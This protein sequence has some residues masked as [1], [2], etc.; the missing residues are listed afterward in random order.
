MDLSGLDDF[1]SSVDKKPAQPN[2]T[3]AP[4]RNNNPGALMPGGKLASYGSLDEGLKALDDN[5]ISYGKKGISTLE[6][7]IKRWA[8]PNENDT[9]SYIAHAA[10]VTGLDPKQ[11][12][13]LSNPLTRLQIAA[14]ITQ[15]ESGTKALY[16]ATP[17]A[18]VTASHPVAQAGGMDLSG[19]DDFVR[20]AENLK[21]EKPVQEKRATP[22][23]ST[24]AIAGMIDKTTGV[25]APVVG[26]IASDVL[27]T[28][29]ILAGRQQ[30]SPKNV[31]KDITALGTAPAG[32]ITKTTDTEAYK[33]P[34]A[35]FGKSLA[36][37][38]DTAYGVVPA[39]IGMG[40]YAAGRL[41][42]KTPEQASQTQNEI[43]QTISNPLGHLFKI[44]EDPAYK[45]NSLRQLTEFVGEHIEKG[46]DWIA[47]KTG[48]PKADVENAINAASIVTPGALAK[49]AKTKPIAAVKAGEAEARQ[50]WTRP[51]PGTEA[52]AP[53]AESGWGQSVGSAA[54]SRADLIQEGIAQAS[55]ELQAALKDIPIN[56]MNSKALERHLE[57]DSIGVQLTRGEATGDPIILSKEKNSRGEMPELA[58]HYQEK[59]QQLM[60]AIFKAKEEAMPEFSIPQIQAAEEIIDIYKNYDIERRKTI[61]AAYQALKDANGGD[62]PIDV[63]AL[64]QNIEAS[65]KDANRTH[66]VPANVEKTIEE[67][68]AKDKM[69]YD[70]FEALRTILGEAERSA[71]KAGNGN[72]KYA[73]GL[74]RDEVEN[75]PLTKETEQLKVL[76]D[77]AR[78]LA[79]SRFDDLKSDKIYK[80]IV[81][82]KVN[83]ANFFDRYITS[84][85]A[86]YAK[87]RQF[88][89]RVPETDLQ[90]YLMSGTMDW[91]IG[92]A[93]ASE[94]KGTPFANASYHRAIKQL[95]DTRKAETI[96]TPELHQKLN[97]IDNVSGY[98][99]DQPYGSFI[100]NANTAV[101]YLARKAEQA[102]NAAAKK[103]AIVSAA[104]EIYSSNQK[105]QFLKDTLEPGAG[106]RTPHYQR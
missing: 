86:N 61:S 34:V 90:N 22:A 1:V 105:E 36:S 23:A 103:S 106:V 47:E 53:M 37:A 54:R 32:N 67:F 92:Q 51:S 8:P 2:K 84:K 74:I 39:T 27:G 85:T 33:S 18:P 100:N 95:N 16:Q 68:S 35:S 26:H 93:K 73:I 82:D 94:T 79:K 50:A 62:F 57:A 66:F 38:V 89:D 42:G 31:E 10:R 96:F 97:T 64:R 88:M 81:N 98:I 7:V 46:A 91:L 80:D 24:A 14:A 13:D 3:P 56:E 78:S 99:Y 29:N 25:A 58:Q 52:A 40:A 87:L 104:K 70:D 69:S 102:V 19:L 6:G 65:L 101:S 76:A 17:K 55:P 60:N 72:E 49:S 5:L 45:E 28:A 59:N 75:L 11:E 30:A 43:T 48:M 21:Q 9:T 20:N 44:T 83:S 15:K 77:K 63:S 41:S 12:I 71:E 4:I